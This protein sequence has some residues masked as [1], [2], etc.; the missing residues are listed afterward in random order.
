M[1]TY[2]SSSKEGW[3]VVPNIQDFSSLRCLKGNVFYIGT[4]SGHFEFLNNRL[5]DPQKLILSLN[6]ASVTKSLILY[7]KKIN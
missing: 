2:L 6:E 7:I 5:Q 1:P 3:R 4:Q